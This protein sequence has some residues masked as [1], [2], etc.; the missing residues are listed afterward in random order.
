[1]LV[2]AL[3]HRDYFINDSIKNWGTS[4]STFLP[5]TYLWNFGDGSTSTAVSPSHTYISQGTY[6]A[7]LTTTDANGCK[8]NIRKK[9]TFNS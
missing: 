8:S 4:F 9:V 6:Y 3:I 5:N 2:N 1:M 7:T